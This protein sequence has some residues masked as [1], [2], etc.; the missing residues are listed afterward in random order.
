MESWQHYEE[1]AEI[2][3]DEAFR[4]EKGTYLLTFNYVKYLY[5]IE[6]LAF[7]P[8]SFHNDKTSTPLSS[9]RSCPCPPLNPNSPLPFDRATDAEVAELEEQG[10]ETGVGSRSNI[11]L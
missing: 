6:F 11:L 7:C 8:F 1:Q 9:P 5:N 3:A 10:D 4:T 2:S